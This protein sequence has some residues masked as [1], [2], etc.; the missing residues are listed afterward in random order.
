LAGALPDPQQCAQSP[1][2][3]VRLALSLPDVRRVAGGLVS[4]DLG[5]P[6]VHEA[7]RFPDLIA[8][9]DA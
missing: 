4:R 1:L 9:G 8:E 3:L 2:Q 7:P 5:T 6:P